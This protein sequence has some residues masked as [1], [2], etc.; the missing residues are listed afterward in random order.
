[1]GLVYMGLP[2]LEPAGPSKFKLSFLCFL[3]GTAYDYNQPAL[4]LTQ[5]T[6]SSIDQGSLQHSRKH[7]PASMSDPARLRQ[8][9]CGPCKDTLPLTVAPVP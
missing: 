7:L 8:V 1:M 5:T 4:G 2:H 9:L 6:S 3:W